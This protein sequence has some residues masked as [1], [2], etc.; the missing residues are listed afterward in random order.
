MPAVHA[1]CSVFGIHNLLCLVHRLQNFFCAMGAWSLR[2]SGMLLVVPCSPGHIFPMQS[3][4]RG[5]AVGKP[6]ALSVLLLIAEGSRVRSKCLQPQA[7]GSWEHCW[8]VQQKQRDKINLELPLMTVLGGPAVLARSGRGLCW[9][10]WWLQQHNFKG[11]VHISREPGN[12]SLGWSRGIW[13]QVFDH[14]SF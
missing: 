5:P 3:L 14:V 7:Q 8:A 12:S 6:R 4:S 1:S 9:K 11:T 2:N 13:I 10:M